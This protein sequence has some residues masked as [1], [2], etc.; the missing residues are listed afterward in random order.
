M[1]SLK[2]S[3]FTLNIVNSLEILVRL[4]PHLSGTFLISVTHT[5]TSHQPEKCSLP[6]TTLS[7][8]DISTQRYHGLV[9]TWQNTS[10]L[11]K[12]VKFLACESEC[13]WQVLSRIIILTIKMMKDII[14]ILSIIYGDKNIHKPDYNR[15]ITNIISFT[16]RFISNVP[17]NLFCIL[18]KLL[19]NIFCTTI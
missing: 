1:E 9:N 12:L 2:L 6:H 15:F 4:G 7:F 13:R 16:L 19:N 17:E 5:P 3:I 18:Y 8:L 11:S 10:L 14:S